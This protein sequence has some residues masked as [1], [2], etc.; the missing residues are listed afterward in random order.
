MAGYKHISKRVTA[1][2]LAGC[3]A[4][5]CAGTAFATPLSK[6]QEEKEQAQDNLDSVNGT[7]QD[8]QGRQDQVKADIDKLDG[9]LATTIANIDILKE[10]IAQ[11]E[12]ELEQANADLE[13]AKETEAEQYAAMKERIS[14]MYTNGGDI[15]FFN[16]LFGANSFAD[17]LNRIEMFASVYSFDRSLLEEYQE[18]EAEIESLV[19][20]IADEKAAKQDQQSDLEAQ[21]T[22]LNNMIAEKRAQSSNF[23]EELAQAMAQAEEYKATI[24]EQNQ[25]IADEVA[26]QQR[27]DA[28]AKKKEQQKSDNSSKN[29]NSSGTESNKG[30]SDSKGDSQPSKG[31]NSSR[32]ESSSG[33]GS[34]S[35]SASG[36]A[37]ANYACQFVGNPY[38]WGGES[39]TNGADCSGFVMAVYAHFGI[40]LPHSSY[41]LRSVGRAVSASEMQPGDIVCY[42]GHVAIYIGGGRI[43]HASNQ[44]DGIKISPNYAYR[45]VVAIRRVL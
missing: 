17:A 6:A 19:T 1:V 31:D 5:G 39:L 34:S 45:T 15:S 26:A 21:Q 27:E 4:A 2:I 44:K 11:K 8:I 9:D 23:D 37:V 32:E 38:V 35:S 28:A 14:Y 22:Y 13:E 7:I 29:N 16:A 42:D 36:S 24:S 20:E 43:V 3:L 41:S 10:G 12:K 30:G 33:S 18:T 25:I 40:S